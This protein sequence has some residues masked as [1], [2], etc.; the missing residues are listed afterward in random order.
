MKVLRVSEDCMTFI[1]QCSGQTGEVHS[2]FERA[3]NLLFQNG[4]LMTIVGGQMDLAPMTLQVSKTSFRSLGWHPGM[5]VISSSE[6]IFIGD[7]KLD[8]THAEVWK[9]EWDSNKPPPV[10]LTRAEMLKRL[11]TFTALLISKGKSEGL[12]PYLCESNGLPRPGACP[13]DMAGNRYVTFIKGRLDQFAEAYRDGTEAG[14]ARAI[15]AFARLVGF[16]PGLTPS[17]DDFVA[18][19]MA[20]SIRAP[21]GQ[22]MDREMLLK[23]NM[24]LAIQAKGKTT[25]ISEAMLAHA[26]LGHVAQKYRKLLDFLCFDVK[27]DQADA[28]SDAAF[29]AASQADAAFCAASQDDAANND[30]SL[31]AATLEALA[32]GDTS[33]TDFMTGAAAALMLSLNA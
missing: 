4:T 31:E 3:V 32:H 14:E 10:P 21:Y 5:P 11:E 6:G 13:C 1:N 33:G 12:L 9:L 8:F 19:F 25:V 20:A 15:T 2:I 23:R 27:G 18:G 26:A 7:F 24:K 22:F 16:G 30:G 29:C 17:S 28:A